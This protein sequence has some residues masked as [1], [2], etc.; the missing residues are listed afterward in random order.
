MDLTEDYHH[1]DN[2]IVNLK[3]WKLG[4]DMDRIHRNP[5]S[6]VSHGDDTYYGYD[7]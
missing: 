5:N 3:S 6:F 2:N 4:P 7:S 1:Y